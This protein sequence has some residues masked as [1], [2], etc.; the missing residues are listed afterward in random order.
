MKKLGKIIT[1]Q[2]KTERRQL[3]TFFSLILYQQLFCNFISSIY[4]I[5]KN[6]IDLISAYFLAACFA[7]R[8]HPDKNRDLLQ[9]IS[10]V[11]RLNFVL[12]KRK[13]VLFLSIDWLYG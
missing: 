1:L 5:E 10:S 3:A 6:S 13:I 8:F 11:V 2:K 9:M 12:K 7:N 4:S